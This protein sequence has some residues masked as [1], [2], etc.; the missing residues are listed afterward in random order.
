MSISGATDANRR[1]TR[2]RIDVNRCTS[3]SLKLLNV[4]ASAADNST[5]YSPCYL[6]VL[7]H[8]LVRVIKPQAPLGL[9]YVPVGSYFPQAVICSFSL[10]TY[11]VVC[12]QAN[13][14]G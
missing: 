5:Y 7:L 14:L 3:G 13:A 10:G 4:F 2:V 12:T 1:R 11:M 8:I 9:E 6:D